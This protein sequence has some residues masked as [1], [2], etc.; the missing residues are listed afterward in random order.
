METSFSHSGGIDGPAG[1]T[2]QVL[3]RNILNILSLKSVLVLGIGNDILQ[4]DGIGIRLVD[5]LRKR[6]F[7]DHIHF[8]TTTLGGL[9]ILEIIR[10]FDRV[11]ILDAIKTDGGVPGQVYSVTPDDF[12]ETLHLSNLHDIHFLTSL[13]LAKKVG[14]QIPEEIRILAVEILE[15]MEFGTELTPELKQRYPEVLEIITRE[16]EDLV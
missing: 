13:E 10:E 9:E 15:D 16:I 6:H 12:R 4:D 3:F 1:L 5:D 14:I 11:V 8:K 7:P 2:H